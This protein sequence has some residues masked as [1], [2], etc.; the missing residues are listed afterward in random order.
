MKNKFFFKITLLIFLFQ[1]ILYANEFII[2]SSEIKIL[3]K[4]K[5]LQAT[6]GVKIISK[7]MME[8]NANELLYD[9]KKLILKVNGNVTIND[10]KNNIL[11]EGEEFVYNKNSGIISS[12]GKSKTN[13]QNN[14]I[15]ESNNLIYDRISYKVYSK[16]KTKIIDL[17][18]NNFVAENFEFNFNTNLLKAKKLSLF[19]SLNNQYNLNFAIV[20]LKENKF[21]GSD[22]FIDF[23]DSLFGNN[24]NNPRLKA[25]SIISEENETRMTKGNFTTCKQ[26]DGK[27]PSWSIQAEEVVHK[28]KERIIEYK[29]AWLRIYDKPVLYFPYFFH[30]DPTVKRQSGFLMPTFQNSN[31]SGSSLQIPYYK[32][33]SENKDMTFYPRLFFDNEI[34]VQSEYRQANKNSDLIFDFSINHDSSDTRNHFFADFKSI[35]KNKFLDIHLETVS[36][37]TYL[38]ANNIQ[39]PIVSNY[40]SLHSFVKYNTLNDDSSFEISFEIFENLDKKKTDRY[41]YIYPNFTYEK[42]LYGFKETEGE[43]ILETNGYKKNYNTN[44]DET[45]LI[46]DLKYTSFYSTNSLI[47]GF[48]NNYEFLIKNLNSSSNNSSKYKNG[49]D[50]KLLSSIMF[51]SNYPLK[52]ENEKYENYFTPKISLKYSPNSTKNNTEL[53]K[54]LIYEDIFLI[55]RIDSSGVEGGESL[56]MG[57]EYS[58][59]NKITESQI[60]FSLANILRLDENPDLPLMNGLSE[61]RSNF[62]G[63]LNF[64]PSEFF[65]LNYQFSYDSDFKDSNYDSIKANLKINNF[66]TSFEFLEEDDSLNDSSYIINKSKYRFNKNYSLNF[67]TSKNLDKNITDYYNLIYEYENDCLT[68]AIEYN[69][70]YYSDGSLKPDENILFSIKIIPFGKLNTPSFSK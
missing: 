63:N 53:N 67:A 51:N 55:D 50:Y 56:T 28:K 66:I 18:N 41:E 58:S 5:I 21:L 16:D 64:I 15:L 46:N 30:P 42:N 68:A 7:D 14:Y 43:L 12:K 39:S 17:E 32:V 19:D 24:E 34:L 38:K 25:N 40:S 6:N 54:R 13:I 4:G 11:T 20:N 45:I 69:K 2:E 62:I 59:K 9:K 65:D 27:C 29:N 31:N 60:N 10:K 26:K 52:K 49:E 23:E 48:Q 36:N 57:V 22:I 3:E 33:I 44:T 70:S 1:N 47:S 37:D 35:E 8:I 61:K